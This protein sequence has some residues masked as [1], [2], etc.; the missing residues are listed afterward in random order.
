MTLPLM[1][2]ALW[3]WTQPLAF[4]VVLNNPVDYEAQDT[5]TNTTYFDGSVLPMEA[6]KLSM[7]PEGERNFKHFT[8]FTR[9]PL[10]LDA[11]LQ[12]EKG[13]YYRVLEQQ[14]WSQGRD[15]N[16]KEYMIMQA[17]APAYAGA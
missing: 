16:Y 12:D 4:Q 6:R 1:T 17:P 5:P 7:R 14:D 3:G 15:T 11:I 2:A 9:Q 10:E 8:L 13:L